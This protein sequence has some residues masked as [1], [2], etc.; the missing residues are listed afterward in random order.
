MDEVAPNELCSS[1]DW[2]GD[3]GPNYVNRHINWDITSAEKCRDR[4]LAERKCVEAFFFDFDYGGTVRGCAIHYEE[5]PCSSTFG[6]SWANAKHYKVTTVLNPTLAP[7]SSPTP[8]PVESPTPAPVGN[9][10]LCDSPGTFVG[11]N[12][13]GYACLVDGVSES[14]SNWG[15]TE[16]SCSDIGGVWTPYD[17]FAAEAYY[18]GLDVND[19]MINEFKSTWAPKCCET[20]QS[21]TPAPVGKPP[22]CDS[23]GTFVGS[24]SAGYACLVDGVSESDSNW[25][26][27]EASC[28]DI[29]GVWTP[30][31]C[32]AAEAYYLGLDV[33]DPMINEFKST[34]A[35]KCCEKP[36][37]CDSPG[38]FVGSNSAG[39]ACLVD[40]NASEVDSNWG[41]TEAS[42]SDIGGVWT[43]YDC[44][45][46]EAYYLGLD[47]ND[48]FIAEF[49]SAW[50][51]QCCTCRDYDRRFPSEGTKKNCFK[52][53]RPDPETRCEVQG[54][55]EYCPVTCNK[56]CMPKDN[57]EGF[58]F[59]G[60]ARNCE[61]VS[62][63]PNDRCKKNRLRSNC[64]E[65]CLGYTY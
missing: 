18:L 10:P 49:K 37:I 61:W 33:N 19:P 57:Q 28:S 9:P 17:C 48:P 44:F 6:A 21:P 15:G 51:P 53:I 54:V 3:I 58:K 24:N 34:W 31:D 2:I 12:S 43:P 13:A 56:D 30:Y 32:F 14:D 27:T 52:N 35:P 45:A 62:Q 59:K 50:A 23:P 40:G 46:A 5:L 39:Y 47:V 8:A 41:G 42:C 63:L 60:V 55:R 20:V 26:G 64:P 1:P 16:A 22:I 29:G 25:G 4:C 7:I 65:T 11:S 36:P 38:T